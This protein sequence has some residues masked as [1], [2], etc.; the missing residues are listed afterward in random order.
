[1]RYHPD[2]YRF[3]VDLVPRAGTTAFAELPERILTT[4]K[5]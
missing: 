4:T 3:V 2:R 1:V 5:S